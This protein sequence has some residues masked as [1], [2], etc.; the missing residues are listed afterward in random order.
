MNC[1]SRGKAV[2]TMSTIESTS[3]KVAGRIVRLKGEVGGEVVWR[4][5]CWAWACVREMMREVR[6]VVRRCMIWAMEVDD[7]EV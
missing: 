5:C 4:G 2:R 7:G 6:V 3:V 1:G